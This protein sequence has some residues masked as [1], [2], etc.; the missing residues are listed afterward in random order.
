M[1][2]IILYQTQDKKSL[3]QIKTRQKVSKKD[4]DVVGVG[5]RVKCPTENS[6]FQRRTPTQTS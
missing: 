2:K 5:D 6:T 1:T 3:K 4:T